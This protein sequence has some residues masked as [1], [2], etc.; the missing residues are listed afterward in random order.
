[1]SYFYAS[2]Q[3]KNQDILPRHFNIKRVTF[4]SNTF[5]AKKHANLFKIHS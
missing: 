3:L 4:D 5:I 2:K 1:M